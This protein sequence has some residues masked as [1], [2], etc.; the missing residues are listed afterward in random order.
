MIKEMCSTV[1]EE[2]FFGTIFLNLLIITEMNDSIEI[3]A[4]ARYHDSKTEQSSESW[5]K[6]H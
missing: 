2:P 6:E 5:K 4:D 3:F 1:H